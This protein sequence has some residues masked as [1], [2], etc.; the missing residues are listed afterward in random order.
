M[1]RIGPDLGVRRERH[2]CSTI[3][4]GSLS[5]VRVCGQVQ[6][7]FVR[8]CFYVLM[9]V[10]FSTWTLVP[11]ICLFDFLLICCQKNFWR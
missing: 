4:L 7:H 8:D 1:L 5:E 9:Q 6:E 3:Q 2:E 10:L 11:R